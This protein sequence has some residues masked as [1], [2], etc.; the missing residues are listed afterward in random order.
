[1]AASTDLVFFDPDIGPEP[2]EIEPKDLDKY[3]LWKEIDGTYHAGHSVMVFNFLRG[4]TSQK[5]RLVERRSELLRGRLPTADVTVLRSHDLAFYFAVHDTHSGALERAT[6]AV[7][8][9]WR[10]V[11]D[12]R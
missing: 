6:G 5:D 11:L 4:G 2:N 1:M 12:S 9:G 10:G 7:L 8:E 3:V